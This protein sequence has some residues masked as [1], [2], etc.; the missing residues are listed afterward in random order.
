MN[1]LSLLSEIHEDMKKRGINDAKLSNKLG[2][3]KG[4]ISQYFSGSTKM[5][6]MNFLELVRYVYEEDTLVRKYLRRFC[7]NTSKPLNLC[8]AMEFASVQRD[9]ELLVFLVNKGKISHNKTVRE[10]AHVYD[11]ICERSLGTLAGESL[12]KKIS[13][14]PIKTTSN[15]MKVLKSITLMYS[16]SDMKEYTSLIKTVPAV[17]LELVEDDNENADITV[18]D[19]KKGYIKDAYTIR[20]KELQLVANLMNNNILAARK[21]GESII[22]EYS[23]SKFPIFLASAYQYL[24]LSYMFEDTY[25]SQLLVQKGIDLL[26]TENTDRFKEK[27]AECKKTL[28][29]IQIDCGN[30]L[31]EINP[32]DL[33]EKA[34][35]AIKKG[36]VEEGIAILNHIKQKNGKWTA[37]QWY[38]MGLATG[39]SYYFEQSALCFEQH[40]NRFYIQIP[41]RFIR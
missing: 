15:E 28:D 25:K 12:F 37:F 9:Y 1:T 38:Y 22:N 4:L 10:W 24:G 30:H 33:G 19:L 5:S 27:I 35:L 20:V 18:T 3:T 26:K 31:N 16:F 29:F 32:D 36:L 14:S 17:D 40:G 34:H 2:V 11:L 6:F 23:S 41:K 21:I 13:Q 7:E 8:I 39:E